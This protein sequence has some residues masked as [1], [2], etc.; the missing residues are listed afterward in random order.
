MN[1]QIEQREREGMV[2]LDLKG[3]LILGRQDTDLQQRLMLLLEKGK[4]AI[5]LNL[6]HVGKIDSS[7]LGM[8]VVAFMKLRK[9]E[10][11]LALFNLQPAHLDLLVL[12]K[13]VTVF[14]VFA[15]ETAAVSSCFPDRAVKSYDVLNLCSTLLSPSTE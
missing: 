6:L 8:L 2:I 5:A 3:S 4:I 14:E 15:D 10:G 7:A 9:V 1:L 11:R 12:T 13:L